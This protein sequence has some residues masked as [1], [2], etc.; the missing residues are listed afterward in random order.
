[1]TPLPVQK[2]LIDVVLQ[3][4]VVVHN[5]IIILTLISGCAINH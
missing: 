2:L 1:M 3:Y 5:N 4:H